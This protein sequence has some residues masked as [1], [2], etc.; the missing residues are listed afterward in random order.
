MSFVSKLKTIYNN[1]SVKSVGIYTFSN[2]FSKAVSFLLLFVFT[3]PVYI[4]PSENGLISLF[5]TSLIFLMPFMS[6]AVIHSTS[7]DFFK[8]DQ[9]EF[10][11]FFTTGMIIPVV[12]TILSTIVLYFSRG[13]LQQ[14]FGFPH[15]FVWMIP[16]VSFCIFCN[17]QLLS[18]ARNNNEPSVYLK[19]NV[20]KTVF[21]FGISFVLV[22]FFAYR[23]LGRIEGILVSYVL[24]SLYAFHYFKKKG[25]LFG[26]IKKKFIYSELIYA[27]PIITLQ[28]SIFAMGSSDKFFLSNFTND[29]NATVGVYSIAYVFASMINIFSM[30]ILQYI[31]PKIY[32]MLSSGN[33]DHIQIKKFFL[34][35][36]GIM[37]IVLL[38]MIAGT[39]LLYHFCINEKY[40]S[41]I[42]YSWLLYTGCYFWAIAYF[43]YSFL[44]FY[45]EKKKILIL[46][47]CGIVISLGFNYALIEKWKDTGA[48]WS[49]FISYLIVLIITLLFTRNHWNKFLVK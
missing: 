9:K 49:T 22:V 43:F 23:W 40:H 12:V 35:Y 36:L 31:F 21:E 14:T 39:P 26:A 32:T 17:E 8:L 6:M 15:M 27:V 19:V 13:F 41:A 20:S 47:L 18:L 10:R 11:D 7:T 33:I 3:N 4:T 42:Q 46:S 30:A 1:P 34:G 29:N 44:L 28:A 2:F 48:A 24:V 45:K 38:A 16:V 37:T 25:Y 5:S